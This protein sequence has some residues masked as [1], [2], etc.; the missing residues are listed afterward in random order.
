LE[1]TINLAFEEKLRADVVNTL[2]HI[3]SKVESGEYKRKSDFIFDD[4]FDLTQ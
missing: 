3:K 2:S 1:K 4:G